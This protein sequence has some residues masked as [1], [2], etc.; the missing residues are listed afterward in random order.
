M[1]Q[2]AEGNGDG[3]VPPEHVANAEPSA[4][5]KALMDH[6]APFDA[7]M[8]QLAEGN[9]DGGVPPEYLADAETAH[10]EALTDHGAETEQLAEGNDDGGVPPKHAAK[11]ASVPQSNPTTSTV[12][13]LQMSHANV[14]RSMNATIHSAVPQRPSSSAPDTVRHGERAAP[15]RPSSSAPDTVRHGERAAPQRPSSSAPDTVRHGERTTL[16]EDDFRF[17]V[18]HVSSTTES[19]VSKTKELSAEGHDGDGINFIVCQP[20]Q[21][22]PREETT[23][24]DEWEGEKHSR[25]K[26]CIDAFLRNNILLTLCISTLRREVME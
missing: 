6:E 26:C 15:E 7:E 4:N 2:L 24:N 16:R 12:Q 25:L 10:T 17:S 20:C 22:T 11:V 19:A 9:G 23:P 13:P 3:G 14:E 5:M 21:P 8:D 1:D 18:R